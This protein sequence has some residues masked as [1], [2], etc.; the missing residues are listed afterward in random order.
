MNSFAR[1]AAGSLLTLLVA[2]QAFAGAEPSVAQETKPAATSGASA[3]AA[4]APAAP[5]PAAQTPAATPPAAT[6]TSGS[7]DQGMKIGYVDMVKVGRESKSGKAAAAS[8]KSKST[9]L[10][11]KIE[12]KQKQLEKEKAAIEAKIDTMSAKERTAKG[13][14]FQKKVEEYQKL[15]R[16][17]EQEMQQ[18]QDKATSDVYKVMKKAA[19]SYAKSHG[20][21]AIVEEKGV[22]YMSDAL[23]PKD[24]TDEI[25]AA[26]DQK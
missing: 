17:S 13:K 2:N 9:K 15:V 14:E 12:A 11:A 4:T 5:S 25:A 10:R 16:A 18:L 24:L 19:A 3:P 1:F 21:A 8:M 7:K 26:M 20:Y 6:A 22:L 23:E